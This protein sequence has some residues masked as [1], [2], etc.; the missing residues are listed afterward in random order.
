MLGPALHEGTSS[1]T[2]WHKVREGILGHGEKSRLGVLEIEVLVL[3]LLAIDGSAGGGSESACC[4][5]S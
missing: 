2:V 4:V 5:E 3:E 1:G